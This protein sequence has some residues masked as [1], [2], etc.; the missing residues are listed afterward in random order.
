MTRHSVPG[1]HANAGGW[2]VVVYET[3][4]GRHPALEY[5]SAASVPYQPRR[6]LLLT[7]LPSPRRD[8]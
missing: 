1:S 2:Q 3:T 5:L 7:V 6:E 8:R 4:S